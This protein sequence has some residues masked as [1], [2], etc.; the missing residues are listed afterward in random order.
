MDVQT[1][2]GV[3]GQEGWGPG[4][5]IYCVVSLSTMGDWNYTVFKVF[6]NSF[7][8]IGIFGGPFFFFCHSEYSFCSSGRDSINLPL[9]TGKYVLPRT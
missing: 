8:D 7:Y 3:E 1:L 9:L 6:S 4:Q 2:R 5:S